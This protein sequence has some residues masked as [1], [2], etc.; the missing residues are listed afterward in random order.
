M[1]L[2][3]NPQLQMPGPVQHNIRDGSMLQTQAQT[4]HKRYLVY[5]VMLVEA[6]LPLWRDVYALASAA[7]Q[8]T[9]CSQ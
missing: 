3:D 6:K 2:A 7:D 4:G 5:L 1:L 8:I 9:H